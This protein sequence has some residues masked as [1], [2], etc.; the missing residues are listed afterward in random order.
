MQAGVA[1]AVAVYDVAV[2]AVVIEPVRGEG[3]VVDAE[4]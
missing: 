2:V 4:S 3:G 1:R